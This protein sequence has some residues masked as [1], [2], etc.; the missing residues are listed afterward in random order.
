MNAA[1]QPLQPEI[2]SS[3][4]F[5]K[6]DSILLKTKRNTHKPIFLYGPV[7]MTKSIVIM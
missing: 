2:P 5:S 3:E 1:T 4:K 7:A 6:R